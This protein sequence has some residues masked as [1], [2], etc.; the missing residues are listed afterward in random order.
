[1]HAAIVASPAHGHIN[2]LLPIAAQLVRSGAK[3]TVVAPSEFAVAAPI[4]DDRE[5][6]SVGDLLLL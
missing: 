5:P 1:M 4:T 6:L 2:P 3:V